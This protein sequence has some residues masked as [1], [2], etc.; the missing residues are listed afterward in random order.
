M[1][2]SVS[3]LQREGERE[4]ETNMGFCNQIRQ[5]EEQLPQHSPKEGLLAIRGGAGFSGSVATVAGGG[6]CGLLGGSLTGSF[7]FL[8]LISLCQGA[9]S[10]AP[11][12]P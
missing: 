6:G 7:F 11:P 1:V 10:P 4:G 8:C 9:S 3:L 12:P 2:A 5:T